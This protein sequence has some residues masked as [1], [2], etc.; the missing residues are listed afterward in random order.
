MYQ[1]LKAIMARLFQQYQPPPDPPQDPYA[2][3]REPS[4]RGPSGRRTAAAVMEPEPPQ[5]VDADGWGR[6]RN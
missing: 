2:G 3:V 5:S 1:R 6:N 4:G